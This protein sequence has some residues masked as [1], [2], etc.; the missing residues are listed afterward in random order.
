V[1]ASSGS[2]SGPSA[3]R[4][5]IAATASAVTKT[6]A[7]S[8]APFAGLVN[9]TMTSIVQGK[10]WARADCETRSVTSQYVA[11]LPLALGA[12]VSP[13]LFAI[14][15]LI[16]ASGDR[17]RSRAWF[18]LLGVVTVIVVFTFV[19]I[20]TVRTLLDALETPPKGWS[21][22]IRLTAALV[23]A[24]LGWR[25]VRPTSSSSP[26]SQPW[27]E[28]RL[29]SA[30]PPAFMLLGVGTMLTNW[31]TLLMYLSAIELVRAAAEGAVLVFVA[32]LVVML[33]TIGPLLVPVLAVTVAGHRADPLLARMGR[34]ADRYSRVIIAT[35]YFVLAVLCATSTVS[36]FES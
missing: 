29:R 22:A 5:R 26:A 8:A 6:I 10:A 14:V 17:P 13:G 20:A 36:V 4:T 18:Y 1:S 11:A 7:T 23:L 3:S 25:Y 32:C 9:A 30:R 33:I 16:L 19:G 2:S 24:W 21:I 12:A 15:L 34:W 35:I 31:S 27:L 28:A